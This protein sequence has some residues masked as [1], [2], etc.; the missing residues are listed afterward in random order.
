MTPSTR[1]TTPTIKWRFECLGYITALFPLAQAAACG[2]A[3]CGLQCQYD[4]KPQHHEQKRPKLGDVRQFRC[5]EV[6]GQQIPRRL[7]DHHGRPQVPWIQVSVTEHA[8]L[9]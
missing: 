8:Q 1:I 3:V 5:V 6:S 2:R 4:A 9:K 7:N